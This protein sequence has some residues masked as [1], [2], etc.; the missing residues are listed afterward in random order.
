MLC[1]SLVSVCEYVNTIFPRLT[2]DTSIR[3]IE[4]FPSLDLHFPS[5]YDMFSSCTAFPTV[6][7]S[8]ELEKK[9][10]Y[11][12]IEVAFLHGECFVVFVDLRFILAPH[13]ENLWL[14]MLSR[15]VTSNE[16]T[17]DA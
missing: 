16:K 3:T 4:I 12:T 9:K 14:I 2:G 7:K 8:P 17:Y 1:C 10:H 5:S 6:Q 15:I 11:C 13:V